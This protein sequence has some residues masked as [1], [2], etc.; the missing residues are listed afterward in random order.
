MKSWFD[1][2]YVLFSR[3]VFDEV[4]T[5]FILES[6]ALNVFFLFFTVA[7]LPDINT[8]IRSLRNT[9]TYGIKCEQ[10]T[11]FLFKPLRREHLGITF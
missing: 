8:T 2:E 10:N 6:S 3:N 9:A 5:A 11:L 4:F 1:T 7:T